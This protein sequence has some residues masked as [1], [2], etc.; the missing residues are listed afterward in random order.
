MPSELPKSLGKLLTA[1]LKHQAKQWLGEEALG[2]AGEALA[3]IVGEG[4]QKRLDEWLDAG[5]TRAQLLRAAERADRYFLEHC[6]DDRLKQAF[7]LRFWDLPSLQEALAGLPEA[8]DAGAVEGVLRRGLAALP[9]APEQ[10]EAGARLYTDALLRSVGLLEDFALPVIVQVLLDLR[11]DTRAEHADLRER[12]D[13]IIALLTQRGLPAAPPSPTLPG[14]LPPGSHLPILPNP[15]FT[16]RE[17]ELEKLCQALV[18]EDRS[19]VI[20]QRALVGMGGIGKTQLAVEFAWRYGY[21]FLGVHWVLANKP[22]PDGSAPAPTDEIR[23]QIEASIAE[24]GRAMCLQPWPDDTAQQAALTLKA[25]HE[26]GPRLVI[27]DNLE[28][29][30]AAAHW[31]PRLRH[32]HI[33][34]LV[35]SRQTQWDTALGVEPLPL[36][37]FTEDESLRFLARVLPPE[38]ATDDERRALHERLGGLP[39][40]LDLAA[41]YLAH[42]PEITVDEYLR[43]LR[44]D[45]P[46]LKNWRKNNP[47]PTQHDKDVAATFAMSWAQVDDDAARRLFLLAGYAIPNEPF[48]REVLKAAAGLD[49]AAYSAAVD[50]LQ[51]LSL[52]QREPSMHPL[53]AEFAR[54]LDADGA[55]LFAWSRALA[56]RCYPGFD[57]GGIWHDPGLVPHARYSLE[58]MKRAAALRKDGEGSNLRFHLAFLFRHFGDLDRA[59]GLYQEALAIDEALG[60]RQGKSATLHAM[61]NVL[62]TRGDLD[63]AMGLYQ[64]SLEIKEALGDRKGKSATLHAM[65]NVLVTRGDLDRAMGLYQEALAI[66]EAL[67]DR[68]GK[69]ATLAMLAQVLIARGDEE[70]GLKALLSSLQTLQQI[71]ATPDAQ[72]VA[73]ILA[74]WRAAAGAERFGALWQKVAGQP[75]P[76]WL[77]QAGE[78]DRQAQAMTPEEFIALA[79]QAA[80]HKRPEA[81]AL[82]NACTQMAAD[83]RLPEEVRALG[84]ALRRILIGEEN[85]DL[86][87]L[88]DAWAEAI[89]AALREL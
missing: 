32:T 27:L 50:L 57:H 42:V 78:A 72:A 46:S 10:V 25:W 66:L 7:T 33:R 15:R 28:D 24:C 47:N 56:W 83:P 11:R 79:I 34:I 35:T 17:A 3:D 76:D 19:M 82:F 49:D 53:L 84:R 89:R 62:V 77:A 58:D 4:V 38:R 26:S 52:V 20:N 81:E 70:E 59:M 48:R 74:A 55:A 12:L 67:G 44:L 75:L 22:A 71:G 45:H 18:A 51:S 80:R 23:K 60:D 69:A 21:R 86:S 6:K 30:N 5:E 13:Q 43:Q 2:A 39:L 14:D 29:L 31:L 16:G 41:A 63:R 88:P 61:A 54:S 87:A 68:Q 65:A 64:E 40:A 36:E 1:L 9:L 37:V 73:G 8:L 85:V